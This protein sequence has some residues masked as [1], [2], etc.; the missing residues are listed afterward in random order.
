MKK[1]LLA[2][3]VAASVLPFTAQAADSSLSGVY[4]GGN[5]GQSNYRAGDMNGMATSTDTNPTGYSLFGGYNFNQHFAIEGGYGNFGNAN[6]S[7][8]SDRFEVRTQSFYAA[9]KGTLPINEKFGVYGKLGVANNRTSV[10]SQVSYNGTHSNAGLY[11][12]VGAE[13]NI[14]KNVAVTLDYQTFGKSSDRDDKVELT[15]VGLRY[16]F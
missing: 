13:Y 16:S 11:A 7:N 4:V 2:S 15:S 5:L 10:N 8:S 14:N 9:A 6:Q 12:G 3:L 1:I